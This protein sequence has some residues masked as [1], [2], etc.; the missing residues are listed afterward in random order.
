VNQETFLSR[1]N[2]LDVHHRANCP[3]YARL[4]EHLFSS[5]PYSKLEI[6]PFL[7]VS[8]FK[9][10]TLKSTEAIHRT[11]TSSGTSGNPSRIF[12]DR[13]DSLSQI[14]TLGKI[15][16][17]RFGQRRRQIFI[18]SH[19]AGD[20]I[21]VNDFSAKRAAAAGFLAMGRQ[22][23]LSDV[24]AG[25]V[26]LEQEPIVFGMTIDIWTHREHLKKFSSVKPIIIHGG[27]WKKL[28]SLSVTRTNLNKEL[29]K[30]CPEAQIV[31]YFGMI[32]QVG[33]VYFDCEYGNFHEH[34]YGKFLIRDTKS[35]MPI[36]SEEF[37]VLQVM[38]LVPKSYPGHSLLTDDVCFMHIEC[39]C[40]TPGRSF[41]FVGRRASAPIRG[42]ANV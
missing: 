20:V 30:L 42:C 3:A 14:A 10:F 33:T 19:E 15:F 35:L 2:E 21:D 4:V 7:H 5:G 16:A 41:E 12:I 13:D 8:A 32:E 37:G 11:L 27:G 34:E 24:T 39:K 25:R 31:N 29:K 36:T 38:S 26:T 22:T 40:G 18:L 28:E 17:S 9:N 1:L 23:K 6:F